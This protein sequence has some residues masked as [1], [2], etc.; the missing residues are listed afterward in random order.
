MFLNIDYLFIDKQF[1]IDFTTMD[2]AFLNK[3]FKCSCLKQINDLYLKYPLGNPQFPV[4]IFILAPLQA[5]YSNFQ[6]KLFH[7]KF[8]ALFR[9]VDTD[10][11][12]QHFQHYFLEAPAQEK[13]GC[14]SSPFIFYLASLDYFQANSQIIL[15]L[16]DRKS[17]FFIPFRGFALIQV[18]IHSF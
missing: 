17:T 16:A 5:S 6:I 2:L 10:S 1:I 8:Y 15:F 11:D 3:N 7:S 18:L 9:D 14:P 4:R 13:T 12:N